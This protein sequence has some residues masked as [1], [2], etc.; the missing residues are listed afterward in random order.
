MIAINQMHIPAAIFSPSEKRNGCGQSQA[1]ARTLTY[2]V[3]RIPT[4]RPEVG[5]QRVG[6]GEK[7]VGVTVLDRAVD[8]N[9]RRARFVVD[10]GDECG[11]VADAGSLVRMNVFSRL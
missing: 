2:E 7:P 3:H 8:C 11:C 1:S 5:I 9:V 4:P 10:L 6:D